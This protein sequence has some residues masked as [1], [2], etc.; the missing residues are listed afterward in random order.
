MGRDKFIVYRTGVLGVYTGNKLC[1]PAIVLIAGQPAQSVGL[2]SLQFDPR[3]ILTANMASCESPRR[4]PGADL[5]I[6]S[7][8]DL[9]IRQ[10]K[11]PLRGFASVPVSYLQNYQHAKPLF[12]RRRFRPRRRPVFCKLR[13]IPRLYKKGFCLSNYKK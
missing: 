7:S 6:Y 10:Q 13:S 4:T 1:I 12:V 9:V 11:I 8:K 5:L 3:V 2:Q